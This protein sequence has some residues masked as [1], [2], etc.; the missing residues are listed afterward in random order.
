MNYLATYLNPKLR[1]YKYFKTEMRIEPYLNV[2]LTKNLFR[3]IARFR[4][5]SHNLQIELGRHKRPYVEREDRKCDKCSMNV[6][7]DE[8]HLLM[9]CPKWYH[10]RQTLMGSSASHIPGFLIFSQ[11]QQFVKI[12]SS[13]IL[14]INFALGHFLNSIFGEF[15]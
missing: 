7:E 15:I 1:T 3:S 6:V 14:A 11:T 2:G 9:V 4:L 12:M 5:S 13:K 8:E 10:Y